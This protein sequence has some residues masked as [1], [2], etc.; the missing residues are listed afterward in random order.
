MMRRRNFLTGVFAAAVTPNFARAKACI[1]KKA[2]F[3][4]A[5]NVDICVLGGSCT[6]VFA[7]VRAARLGAKVAIVEQA[8]GFGGVAVNG[9]VNVWHSF[10]DTEFKR[11]I[12]GGMSQEVVERLKTRGAVTTLEKNESIAFLLNPFEL[13]T[14][15][16]ELVLEAK[17]IPFLH[18]LFSEPYT[19]DGKIVGA[20]IDGKSGRR[21]IRAKY[22]I[23]AT[24]D[25]DFCLRG[26]FKVYTPDSVQPATM[27]ALVKNFDSKLIIKHSKEFNIPPTFIWDALLP[28]GDLRLLAG[29]RISGRFMADSEDLTFAE[30]EGRRQTRA[31]MDIMRKYGKND[32]KSHL[33]GLPSYIGIRETRHIASLHR[34]TEDE[35]LN[36]VRYPDAIANGS[37]R[38]DVHHQDRSGVTFHYLD[39]TAKYISGNAPVKEFMWRKKTLPENPTFYQMPLRSLIP[40]NSCNVIAAGRMIDAAPLAFSG[41]RVMVNM[42]QLGEAAGVATYLALK[43]GKN[44]GDV[45]AEEVRKTLASGGSIII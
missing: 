45:S 21:I 16:D 27:C 6:G 28:G 35:A 19:E 7:A 29:T 3:K 38:F 25:A 5:A 34:I 1:E 11:Q 39:G 24:G 26:G 32:A 42:N 15:L 12:I 17:V 43:S 13:K 31:I 4:E 40:Q 37:Y 33:L 22:F 23:D 44:I 18:S 2:E 8:N 41:I 20:I 36:G 9:L 30:I 14:E 10:M